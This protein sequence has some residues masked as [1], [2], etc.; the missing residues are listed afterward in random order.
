MLKN[1][2]LLA[3]SIAFPPLFFFTVPYLICLFL[4]Y[5]TRK[6][7]YFNNA[8]IWRTGEMFRTGDIDINKSVKLYK[9]ATSMGHAEAAFH[10][11]EMYA[12]GISLSGF[13][14]YLLEP[15]SHVSQAYFK[16]CHAL[17]PAT[18]A[19]LHAQR[20]QM[21]ADIRSQLNF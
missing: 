18:F 21:L 1:L 15:D 10:L 4:T 9:K 2:I 13:S 17:S 16:R 3:V 8:I 6:E 5:N 14:G 11:G 19:Q 12:D 20:E 7:K